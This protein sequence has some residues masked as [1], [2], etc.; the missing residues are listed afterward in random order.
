[1]AKQLFQGRVRTTGGSYKSIID[2][3]NNRPIDVA[4]YVVAGP[5]Q[6]RITGPGAA[7]TELG[8]LAA[9]MQIERAAIMLPAAG[10]TYRL[11]LPAYAGY[12]AQDIVAALASATTTADATLAVAKY[13]SWPVARPVHFTG[14]AGTTGEM[15]IG[16]WVIPID[17]ARAS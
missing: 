10:G 14:V 4:P 17:D 8:F 11:W 2:K 9:E 15:A 1:M 7:T 5:I 3:R 13:A 6:W 16:L 12:A